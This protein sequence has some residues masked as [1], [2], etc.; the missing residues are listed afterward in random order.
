MELRV[1]C[2]EEWSQIVERCEKIGVKIC[3]PLVHQN[4]S[5]I[6]AHESFN[7]SSNGLLSGNVET[8]FPYK[9]I[10]F[11]ITRFDKSV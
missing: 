5:F 8:L 3:F 6:S 4:E 9:L 7:Q 11:T 10:F 2:L 1:P